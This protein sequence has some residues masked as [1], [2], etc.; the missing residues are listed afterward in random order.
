MVPFL[1]ASVMSTKGSE[2]PAVKN[3]V[4]EPLKQVQEKL[5]RFKK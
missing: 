2:F 3:M 1:M 4:I 5:F